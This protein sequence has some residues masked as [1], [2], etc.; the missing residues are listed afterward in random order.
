[1]PLMKMF[2][3]SDSARTPTGRQFPPDEQVPLSWG[4]GE[5]HGVRK[6]RWEPGCPWWRHTD[7]A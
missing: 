2:R 4:M 1:M 7:T 6:G 5:K 3:I